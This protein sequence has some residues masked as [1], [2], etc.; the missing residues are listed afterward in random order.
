MI[1]LITVYYVP[2]PCELVYVFCVGQMVSV[3][4]LDTLGICLDTMVDSG[5]FYSTFIILL[6]Y[7]D[8]NIVLYFLKLING[9]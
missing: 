8:Y 1:L 4:F 9:Y 5:D 2:H 3:H 6:S 7:R